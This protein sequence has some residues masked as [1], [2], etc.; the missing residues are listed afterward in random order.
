MAVY[1]RTNE[2]GFLET[3]Y[4]KVIDGV[5]TDEVDYLSAIEEGNFVIA[6]ANAN[7]DENGK[8]K[9]ELI[10]CRHKGE[11]TFMNADQIQYRNNFV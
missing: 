11:S 3:P 1:S 4:R 2:Y 9:D 10:P 6:Q 7:V 8:L 5:I